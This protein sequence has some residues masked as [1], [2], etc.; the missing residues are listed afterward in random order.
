[1]KKLLLGAAAFVLSTGVFAQKKADDV[2]K[3]KS[4]TID[5]G[6]I[7]QNKPKTVVFEVKNVSNKPLII[8][9]A[10]P[11]CGC[12]IGDY[13]KEP[14]A[15]GK[16]GQ[17]KATY[18]AANLN[19]FEKHLTVKFGGVDEVKNITIKGEVLTAVDYAKVKPAT[20]TKTE[21]KTD[22]KKTKTK[23]KSVAKN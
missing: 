5:M 6:K 10:N 13:T 7:E 11:T 8:E 16:S 18:N 2:A 3:F 1:M 19:A 21:T 15:P 22:G 4:E 14:I 17:I 9:S 23:T 20:E 12:T